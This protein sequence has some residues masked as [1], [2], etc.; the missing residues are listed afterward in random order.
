MKNLQK[1]SQHLITKWQNWGKF[2]S[3]K[4]LKIGQNIKNHELT[5]NYGNM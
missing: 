1:G 5:C 2:T 3:S 4:I